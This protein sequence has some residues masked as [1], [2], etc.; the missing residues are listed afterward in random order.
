[1]ISAA[2]KEESIIISLHDSSKGAIYLSISTF[3]T[4]CQG[5]GSANFAGKNNKKILAGFF[6]YLRSALIQSCILKESSNAYSTV[7]VLKL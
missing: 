2:I 6:D 4:L 3:G 7:N 5:P 1:M